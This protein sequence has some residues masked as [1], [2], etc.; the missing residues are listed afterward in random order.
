MLAVVTAVTGLAGL[1]P[2]LAARQ[3]L[4]D[5]AAVAKSVRDACSWCGGNGV[6]CCGNECTCCSH[7]SVDPADG[8]ASYAVITCHCGSTS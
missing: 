5:R 8:P 6:D 1:M 2:S 4:K 7:L 3:V